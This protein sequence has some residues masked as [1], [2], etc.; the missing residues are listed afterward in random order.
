MD[1]SKAAQRGA[2]ARLDESDEDDESHDR[3]NRSSQ[4]AESDTFDSQDRLGRLGPEKL[5]GLMQWREASTGSSCDIPASL[6]PP[7]ARPT[8]ITVSIDGISQPIARMSI[9]NVTRTGR[10]ASAPPVPLVREP[11]SEAAAYPAGPRPSL[12]AAPILTLPPATGLAVRSPAVAGLGARAA[13]HAS[14]LDAGFS[15]RV[16]VHSSSSTSASDSHLASGDIDVAH[17]SHEDSTDQFRHS[18]GYLMVDHFMGNISSSRMLSGGTGGASVLHLGPLSPDSAGTG[19]EPLRGSRLALDGGAPQMQIQQQQSPAV[20]VSSLG[21]NVPGTS[22]TPPHHYHA[23]STLG[24]PPAQAHGGGGGRGGGLTSGTATPSHGIRGSMS[25]LVAVVRNAFQPAADDAF[26]ASSPSPS[27]TAGNNNPPSPPRAIAVSPPPTSDTPPRIGTAPASVATSRGLLSPPQSQTG[28]LLAHEAKPPSS[29]P[30]P[31]PSAGSGAAAGTTGS[32]TSGEHGADGDTNSMS[33]ALD[34]PEMALVERIVHR[35]R[36]CRANL[37][38][39]QLE[40][41]CNPRARFW[42]YYD[43]VIRMI[44]MY[45]LISIPTLL[46]FACDYTFEYRLVWCLLDVILI[47]SVA[48][49]LT[50]PRF[51]SFGL[52]IAE[53]SQKRRV[54]LGHA[55]SKLEILAVI[56]LDWFVL[57]HAMVATS[58][59]SYQ[60]SDPIYA[61]T[62]GVFSKTPRPELVL[63]GVRF[64]YDQVDVPAATV[65]YAY[66]RMLRLLRTGRTLIWVVNLRLPQLAEPISRLIKTLVFSVFLSHID[67]CA[68]WILS[69][70]I[71]SKKKWLVTESVL[72]DEDGNPTSFL[73]R[74]C[75]N[76]YGAQKALYFMPR[77]IKTMPEILFQAAEMLAAAVLYG[78]IFGNLASIVRSLDSQAGLDKAA[79]VRNFKRAF[80]REF[81]VENQLPPALQLKILDQEE[82]EWIHKKGMDTD[83]LFSELPKPIRVDVNIHLYY[84]LIANV[85]IFKDHATEVFIVALCQ[86]ISTINITKGF[87]ICKAGDAGAEMYFIRKGSVEIMTPDESRILVTL[88][89][90]S[91]FGE[92]ALFSNVLRT[93]TA[94]TSSETQLCV[95]KK[96]DFDD[97]LRKYPEIG[98]VFQAEIDRRVQSNQKRLQ[99]AAEKQKREEERERRRKRKAEAAAAAAAEAAEAA[100]AAANENHHGGGRM[101]EPIAGSMGSISNLSS[102]IRAR[103]S[104][105][106]T[107]LSLSPSPASSHNA[108][109]RRGSTNSAAGVFRPSGN[110]AGKTSSGFLP[111]ATELAQRTRDMLLGSASTNS[112]GGL[113]QRLSGS[114]MVANSGNSGGGGVRTPSAL[115][116]VEAE[117][118]GVRSRSP[119]SKLSR[120]DSTPTS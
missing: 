72:F 19:N 107:N 105:S 50:R 113:L 117:E 119:K 39:M 95:L 96:D 100:A 55:M 108:K 36:L 66:L 62:G 73:E 6:P 56:P 115:S 74:Y 16:M 52:L 11:G 25:T 37:T 46:A 24:V 83:R 10:T 14:A 8:A 116:D 89:P 2:Y 69:I 110:E 53:R 106:L 45:N 54:Y 43:M 30:Q 58:T 49:E 33:D 120:A 111:S 102:S 109:P 93:A 112:E 41:L 59:A 35:Y 48:V 40:I 85:P 9:P 3:L 60:C 13:S 88:M 103:V 104:G 92:F 81:M 7:P 29:V 23:S 98:P 63:Q 71:V 26:P 77:E 82:F 34:A 75:R 28:T 5:Q 61:Y 79:K 78:S 64:D 90:G 31:P 32:T 67:A 51:D 4:D 18:S 22:D 118:G 65:A 97:I 99:E 87:Y 84:N 47:A 27:S 42:G 80:L 86:R 94:R 91:F 38:R 15:P 12:A 76:F 57:F 101:L 21:L 114:S 1:P 20:Q 70:N 44:D 68:Y 17:G